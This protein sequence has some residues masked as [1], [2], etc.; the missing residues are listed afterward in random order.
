VYAQVRLVVGV[1]RLVED[2]ANLARMG[3]PGAA[4]GPAAPGAKA[5][6]VQ[7]KRELSVR[8][9]GMEGESLNAPAEIVK[10]ALSEYFLY[11][12]G[13]RGTILNGWSRRLPSFEAN[14]VP[15]S[16]YYKYERERWSDQVMRYYR[17]KNETASKLGKDPLPDGEVKAFRVVSEDQLHS[18]AGRTMVKYIPVNEEVELELGNDLEV[19]VKPTLMNWTKTDLQFDAEGNVK[20]WTARETWE[21]ELQNSK[22][23]EVVVDIRRNF[24]G[25]WSLAT[26]APYEKVDANKVKWIFPLQPHQRQKFTYEITT[27]Y[28]TN[29]TK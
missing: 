1:I 28:G 4:S 18:F 8:L 27:R 15:I 25:D 17:F 23:I 21:F 22:D 24:S 14:E 20:G 12:V 5:A 13:G 16:S 19:L 9:R 11:T 26:Q 2:I 6:F 3:R 7:A 29:A 10:E